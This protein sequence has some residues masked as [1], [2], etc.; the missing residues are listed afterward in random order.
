MSSRAPKQPSYAR[1]LR[2]AF[3]AARAHYW[4][5]YLT[6]GENR[7]FLITLVGLGWQHAIGHSCVRCLRTMRMLYMS[8][9]TCRPIQVPH[10]PPPPLLLARAGVQPAPAPRVALLLTLPP[11]LPPPLL[12]Q[13]AMVPPLPRRCAPSSWG[14]PPPLP[15]P[16]M[17]WEL[18]VG[19]VASRLLPAALMR[20][21]LPSPPQPLLAQQPVAGST[22]ARLERG[23]PEAGPLLTAARGQQPAGGQPRPGWRTQP[24]SVIHQFQGYK[25]YIQVA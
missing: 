11:A 5:Y 22:P 16:W 23:T 15:P 10:H 13:P 18:W 4:Q 24:H 9:L 14:A 7:Q 25:K 6:A 12:Q 1:A 17:C 3:M 19:W 2:I 21:P 20:A 8:A